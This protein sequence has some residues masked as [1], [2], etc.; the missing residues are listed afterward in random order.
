MQLSGRLAGV[1]IRFSTQ[2]I[3]AKAKGG[4]AFYKA[5]M[6]QDVFFLQRREDFR[7]PT[8]G[9]R[10]TFHALRGEGGHQIIKGHVNDLSRRGIG[11]I[12]DDP[13]TLQ[14]GEI[15][16]SCSLSIDREAGEED[17][18]EGDVSFSLEVCFSANNDQRGITRMGGRFDTIDPE[19]MRKVSQLLNQLERAQARRL[20]GT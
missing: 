16:P 19:S 10:I 12:L 8:S 14:R 7:V 17:W 3:D 20:H 15:L 18:G 2:L 6:P 5:E 13:I 1:D 11:V 4:V 9:A